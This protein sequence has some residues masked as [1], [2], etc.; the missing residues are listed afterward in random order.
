VRHLPREIS[1]QVGIKEN[2]LVKMGLEALSEE[3]VQLNTQHEVQPPSQFV[4][5]F[6]AAPVVDAQQSW[7]TLGVVGKMANG[8]ALLE[9]LS[10]PMTNE[11][12]LECHRKQLNLHHASK[13]KKESDEREEM[14]IP[15]M[16]KVLSL[17]MLC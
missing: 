1:K 13:L 5:V 6:A 3:R 16:R 17:W 8:P 11:E 4:D 12:A 7:Q 10:H 2:A 15:L 14:T 9:A